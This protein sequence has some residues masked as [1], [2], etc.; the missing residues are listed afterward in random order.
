MVDITYNIFLVDDDEEDRDFYK[1]ALKEI[2]IKTKTITFNNG[3]GL[4]AHLDMDNDKLPAI[5]FVDLNLPIM[6]GEECVEKIRKNPR[7]DDIPII[8]YSTSVVQQQVERLK[9]LGANLF[10]QKP[11]SFSQLKSNL[12]RSISKVLHLG[13]VDTS[14]IDFIIKDEQ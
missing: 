3:I 2:Q 9:N 1:D 8:A 11:S 7:F 13:T 10:F 6:S 4:I 14:D 5:I 12:E